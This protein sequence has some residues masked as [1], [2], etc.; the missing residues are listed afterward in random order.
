MERP[1]LRQMEEKDRPKNDLRGDSLR[2]P[3]H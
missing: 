1:E 3:S 2:F